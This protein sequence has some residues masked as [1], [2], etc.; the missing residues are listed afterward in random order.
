MQLHRFA[1]QWHIISSS[2]KATKT[3]AKRSP[4]L[5]SLP[6][7]CP[8]VPATATS[9]ALAPTSEYRL[10]SSSEG[11]SHLV[12]TSDIQQYPANK[13]E[14][15]MPR[16]TDFMGPAWSQAGLSRAIFGEVTPSAAAAKYFYP[17]N[18]GLQQSRLAI[19]RVRARGSST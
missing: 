15:M 8:R 5:Q 13:L 9:G 12:A 17:L 6:V 2:A 10:L 1:S 11:V 14:A 16:S 7:D 4:Q 3:R 19:D 18:H